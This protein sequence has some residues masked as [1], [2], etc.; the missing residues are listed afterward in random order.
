MEKKPTTRQKLNKVKK[1]IIEVKETLSIFIKMN[2]EYKSNPNSGTGWYLGK[3][4]TEHGVE[5]Q[6]EKLK[7]EIQIYELAETLLNTLIKLKI[8]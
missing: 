8:K 6:I 7:G 5:K 2:N 3:H 1:N 4:Y